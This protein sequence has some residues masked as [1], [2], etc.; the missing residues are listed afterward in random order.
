VAQKVRNN[1]KDDRI[2]R[3]NGRLLTKLFGFVIMQFIIALY[4]MDFYYWQPIP[5]PNYYGCA[6]VIL[7]CLM[8]SHMLM[9]Q[10]IKDAIILMRFIIEHPINFRNCFIPFSIAFLKFLVELLIEVVTL[11]MCITQT[12]S[13]SVVV[14]FVAFIILSDLATLYAEM[15]NYEVKQ[16]MQ[17]HKADENDQIALAATRNLWSMKED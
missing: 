11:W 14:T 7:M 15:A 6:I 5:P 8:A 1:I 3:R 2:T 17:S 9:N 4:T 12:D 10:R 16:V 13:M